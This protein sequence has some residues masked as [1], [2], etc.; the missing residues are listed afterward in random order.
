MLLGEMAPNLTHDIHIALWAFEDVPNLLMWLFEGEHELQGTVP[1][2]LLDVAL[3]RTEEGNRV[4]GKRLEGA[5]GHELQVAE[6]G[7]QDDR[8]DDP[9]AHAVDHLV[10]RDGRE[11]LYVELLQVGGVGVI[12]VRADAG[13]GPGRQRTPPVTEHAHPADSIAD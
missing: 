8:V 6:E 2:D 7:P 4:G 5:A 12:G 1:I 10:E 3:L 11:H 9:L 13:V